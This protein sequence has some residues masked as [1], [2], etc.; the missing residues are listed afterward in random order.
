MDALTST[1]A[2]GL[3][4]RLESLD[5]LANNLANS[6]T[7]GYKLDREF[8]SLYTAPEAAVTE[9]PVTAPVV[10]RQWTDFSQ[11]ALSPTGNPHDLALSGKGFFAVDGPSGPL[12]TRQGR[13][14][15]SLAGR[16]V[17]AEG[18]PVRMANGRKVQLEPDK[19]LEIAEDGAVRQDG[20]VLGQLDLVDFGNPSVLGKRG[21]S[22]FFNV[23]PKVSP[24]PPSGLEVWQGKLEN[25]NVSAAES[26]VRLINVLRQFETLQKAISLGAEMNRKAIEEV[27][28][29]GS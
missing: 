19:A 29:V 11:G 7:G 10:E 21:N 25:S 1:A 17:S 15:V 4:A 20:Q 27:A 3:R 18:Y 12:Y 13:F 24:V 2:S 8:Y 23:D 14:R 26:A 6:G 5:M 9:F 28:R 22:Y 16:L